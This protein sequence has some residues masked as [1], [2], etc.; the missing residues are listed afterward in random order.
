MLH[1]QVLLFDEA[2]EGLEFYRHAAHPVAVD[3]GEERGWGVVV[4]SDMGQLQYFTAPHFGAARD[5]L[6][7]ARAFRT[8]D[9][10]SRL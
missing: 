3:W 6:A 4:G 9:Q 8:K 5:A 2:G 10:M 7:H 1:A